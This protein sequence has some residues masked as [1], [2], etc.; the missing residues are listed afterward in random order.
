[1]G[2]VG[3]WPS[4]PYYALLSGL[5][6]SAF[7]RFLRLLAQTLAAWVFLDAGHRAL[8]CGPTTSWAGA[9]GGSGTRGERLMPWLAGTARCTAGGHGT[10]RAG[11]RRDAAAVH[12]RLLAV[13]A[14]HLPGAPGC[15]CV[16]SR[17]RRPARADVYLAYGAGGSLLLFAV[18]GHRV[19]RG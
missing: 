11:F 18:R 5:P 8:A 17:L 14:G 19:R 12:L 1:M 7:T 13:P 6:D 2:Y 3:W 4:L 9:A 15:W 16:G 10:K